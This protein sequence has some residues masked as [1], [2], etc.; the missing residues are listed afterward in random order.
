[1]FSGGMLMP[2]SDYKDALVLCP[3]KI[4]L[5]FIET[6]IFC[7]LPSLSTAVDI[8]VS[9]PLSLIISWSSTLSFFV[10]GGCW[11]GLDAISNED[12][13]DAFPCLQIQH[14]KTQIIN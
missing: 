1:M 2:T 12:D 4:M 10:L 8:L 9:S 7:F 14:S 3:N 5:L 6:Y 13:V 11:A